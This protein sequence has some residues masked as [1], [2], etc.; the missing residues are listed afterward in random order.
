MPLSTISAA[1]SG[2]V[3]S[4]ATRTASMMV[5]IGPWHA[6]RISS[7][8]M[9]NIFGM[10]STRSLP[11]T[12]IVFSTSSEAAEPIMILMISAVLS[13]MSRLYSRLMYCMMA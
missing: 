13:P 1:S 2:G 6:L 8:L 7:E 3:C 9:V 11:L 10:P 4:R 5:L 12:S